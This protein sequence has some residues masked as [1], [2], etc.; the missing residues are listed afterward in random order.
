VAL[1]L[2]LM[3]WGALL[4]SPAGRSTYFAATRHILWALNTPKTSL[5]AGLGPSAVAGG[6]K[7]LIS[8]KQNLNIEAKVIVS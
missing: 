1:Q 7:C 6:C 8:I 5:R 4:A 3:D 2:K